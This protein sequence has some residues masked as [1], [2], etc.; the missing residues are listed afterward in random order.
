[1]NPLHPWV[2]E[3][4]RRGRD[5]DRLRLR[6][7]PEKEL[8]RKRI[9]SLVGDLLK[10]PEPKP[11]P[12][13]ER[14]LAREPVKREPMQ[15]PRSVL[16]TLEYKAESAPGVPV[17]VVFGREPGKLPKFCDECGYVSYA[18][19]ETTC[20][21]YVPEPV[22]IVPLPLERRVLRT[23]LGR[24]PDG[25]FAAKA[26]PGVGGARQAKPCTSYEPS[27]FVTGSCGVC[28]FALEHHGGNA[29]RMQEVK[30]EMVLC[31]CGA[32]SGQF[33][34]RDCPANPDLLNKY[35]TKPVKIDITVPPC[36]GFENSEFMPGFCNRCGNSA[37][38]HKIPEIM[39]KVE[40]LKTRSK[41]CV[42]GLCKG[43]AYD[44]IFCAYHSKPAVPEKRT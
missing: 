1:M 5:P 34:V 18:N 7:V 23:V 19:H 29:V 8:E 30:G 42:V 2:D 12:V 43:L 36:K 39:V 26:T 3:Q 9:T 31:N 4:K 16:D 14:F 15:V 32:Q 33:H 20:S 28:G 25:T 37:K 40:G 21:R 35:P 38:T 11:E 22:N 24:N 10:A 44:G 13:Q 17:P 41:P 27:I 6:I